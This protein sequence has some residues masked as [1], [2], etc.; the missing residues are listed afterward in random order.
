MTSNVRHRRTNASDSLADP[1]K[2][3]YFRSILAILTEATCD[4]VG[5]TTLY[6]H[7][8][9][10]ASADELPNVVRDVVLDWFEYDRC[11][12]S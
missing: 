3:S 1:I 11:M 9:G 8:R 6:W 2:L 7:T 4:L 5:R 12:G 10:R